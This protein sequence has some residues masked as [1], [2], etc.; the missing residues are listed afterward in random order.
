MDI[1]D[2]TDDQKLALLDLLVLATYADGRLTTAE[3]TRIES[4]LRAMGLELEFE[5]QRHWDDSVTRVRQH[6]QTAEK[7][8]AHAA[9][10]AQHFTRPEHRRNVNEWLKDLIESDDQV[11]AEESHFLSVVREVFQPE[12]S[13]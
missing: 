4:L 13:R 2:F 12:A 11:S 8:R 9:E 7:A 10:L 3:D 1:T 5:R 6:A